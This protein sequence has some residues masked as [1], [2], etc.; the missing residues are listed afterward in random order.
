MREKTSIFRLMILPLVGLPLLARGRTVPGPGRARGSSSSPFLSRSWTLG[1][2]CADAVD[3]GADEDQAVGAAFA[4]G[5]GEAGLGA[6]NLAAE[7]VAL[8]ALGLL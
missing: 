2:A 7:G 4:V 5:S 1:S 3:V 8:A 6:A